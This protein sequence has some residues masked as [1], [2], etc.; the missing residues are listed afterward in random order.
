[1]E[2]GADPMDQRQPRDR[3]QI[4]VVFCDL[5][6]ST[7]HSLRLDPEE[8]FELIKG[9]QALCRDAVEPYG[10]FVAQYLGDGVVIYFG[11]PR[12]LEEAPSRAVHAARAIVDGIEN[13][14]RS[15]NGDA[16]ARI[17]VRIGI[18]TGAVV[19]AGGGVDDR[20]DGLAVGAAPNVAS[21]L[22][23]FAPP[24]GVVVSNVTASLLAGLFEV[25]DLGP[26]EL[27]GIGVERLF[28][29]VG[30]G[31][32]RS[33]SEIT[34]RARGPFVG[35]ATELGRLQALQ[36]EARSGRPRCA[37]IVG[38]AGIGK[39]RLVAELGDER[40]TEQ[41]PLLTWYCS[42]FHSNTALM[43]VT[44]ALE[45]ALRFDL[46]RSDG[47]SPSS[48]DALLLRNPQTGSEP[49]AMRSDGQSP[50]SRDALLLRNPQTGSE[51]PAMRSDGQSPSSRDAD[52][53]RLAG[54]AALVRGAGLPEDPAVALLADLLGVTGPDA[55]PPLAMTPE[56]RRLATLEILADLATY[57]ARARGVPLVVEDLQWGDPTTIDLVGTLLARAQGAV[58]ILLTTRPDLTA[59]WPDT[60]APERI[61][62]QGISPASSQELVRSLG[63]PVE[64]PAEVV[65]RIVDSTD[66]VPLFI[67]ELTKSWLEASGP[68][69]TWNVSVPQTLRDTL[70]ARIDRLGPARELAQRAAVIGRR[71][72]VS[73]LMEMAPSALPSEV[74]TLR[75]HLEALVTAGLA[76]QV[77]SPRG[78][79]YEFKH[80]LIQRAA[81]DSLPKRAQQKLHGAVADSLERRLAAGAAI[82][83]ELIAQHLS[84]AHDW[85]RAIPYW[86]GAC[87]AALRRSANREAIAH[88]QSGLA[89]MGNLAVTDERD[90]LELA[91]LSCLGPALIATTGFASDAVGDVYRRARQLSARFESQPEF[92]PSLWGSWVFHLVRG[93]LEVARSFA[94]GILRLGEAA[95]DD[96]ML[97]EGHWTRGDALYWLGRLHEAEEH[98]TRAIGLYDRERHHGNAFRFG[99]DPGVAAWCY[100]S[101]VLWMKGRSGAA[102][103]AVE[104]AR[105]L[106][107]EL[108][109]PFTTAWGLVFEFLH[110]IFMRAPAAA[111]SAA[112]R[113]IAFC[114]EQSH[115]FWLAAAIVGKGWSVAQLGDTDAGVKQ[116]EEGITLYEMT[117]SGIAQAWWNSLLAETLIGVGRI[118]EARRALERA[119]AS[120]QKNGEVI[121]T[122]DLLRIDA[123]LRA[124]A[125]D[126]TSAIRMARSAVGLAERIGALGPGLRAA[127]ALYR[128]GEPSP[129]AAAALEGWIAACDDGVDTVNLREAR[130]ALKGRI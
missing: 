43:P 127:T 121:T 107:E 80:A 67:E 75:A 54:L 7:G 39:S 29:V 98:L 34:S 48:R 60:T 113:T 26:T 38:E 116:M 105:R 88:A 82:P 112:E 71:F 78:D 108:R 73:L 97:V 120:A 4:T 13:F 65:Q 59:S 45:R 30:P 50:S 49:P 46:L 114:A 85:Q 111:G 130:A 69:A 36:A 84:A 93:E 72:E 94:E 77:D 24:G 28:R 102:A 110:H 101:F 6:D 5:V 95:G 56:R 91:L 20:G 68:E 12:A 117:G 44:E 9:Y 2:S 25:E 3:R 90:A 57:E 118:S 1:M 53:D 89:A 103:A 14:N 63:R 96:R 126:R 100:R 79:G 35:R 62:L 52:R 11:Y 83:F 66:G 128:F 129:A 86:L 123:E 70:A 31:A 64:V 58:L 22:Q 41:V 99:Q 122:I 106:A 10:G 115:P 19:T 81:Y 37:L 55:G 76:M 92:F 74:G 33:R 125:G 109:H 23:S 15:Q 32:A 27:K 42:P 8:F 21:R 47:Q 119:H 104:A 51:P 16:R 124:V 61:E 40:P 17:A 87:Q 18:H